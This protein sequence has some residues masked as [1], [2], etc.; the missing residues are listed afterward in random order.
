MIEVEIMSNFLNVFKAIPSGIITGLA[1]SIPLGPAGIESVKRTISKGYKEGFLV[2]MGSLTA[3]L[4]YLVIIN[5]GLSSILDKNKQTE[6]LFWI[7]SGAILAAIGYF[8]I[9][10]KS[11]SFKPKFLANA[12]LRSLPFLAGFFITFFNPM[13]LTLWLTLSGTVIRFWYYVSKVCYYVF[14]LSI[15]AGMVTWFASLNLLALK[16]FKIL[17]PKAGNGT[18]FLLMISICV[19]GIGF[20]IFGFIK[21]FI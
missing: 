5:C 17:T 18:T 12:N 8:S 9:K 2:S 10:D 16:G 4:V 3:D 20:M 7:I 1:I 14:L 11:S 13:T 15:W 19:I 6:A 21:L